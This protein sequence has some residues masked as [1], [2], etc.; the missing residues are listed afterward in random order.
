MTTTGYMIRRRAV[1]ISGWAA[2]GCSAGRGEG[3][4][5]RIATKGKGSIDP[6]A[7]QRRVKALQARRGEQ[8]KTF[9]DCAKAYLVSHR[10]SWKNAKHGQ[11]WASTLEPYA[12]LKIGR[13]TAVDIDTIAI[14]GI[15]EPILSTKPE[16]A[17]RV[18]GRIESVLDWA[19]VR[20]YRQGED[21]ARWKGHLDKLL[22]ARSKVRR[23]E[24]HPAL[25]YADMAG[26]MV[27]WPDARASQR[28][29]S[30]SVFSLLPA[31]VRSGAR[32]GKNST[33]MRE[34]VRFRRVGRRPARSIACRS[35]RVR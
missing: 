30:N 27:S 23:V 12:Y 19:A 14:L 20:G 29:H 13:F 5:R 10:A 9:A 34:P 33:P 18:R 21:P 17:S 35:L 11:Q 8:A 3:A 31:V 24:R 6:V 4:C 26:F 25:P 22:P 2:S 16:T 7:E 1:P 15:I 32:D 28:V